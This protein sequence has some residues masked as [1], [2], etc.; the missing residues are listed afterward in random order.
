MQSRD[1]ADIMRE[2][3]TLDINAVVETRNGL[4]SSVCAGA[5]RNL[6]HLS[7]MNASTHEAIEQL[8]GL[9]DICREAN[10]LVVEIRGRLAEGDAEQDELMQAM[11]GLSRIADEVR[12]ASHEADTTVHGAHGDNVIVLANHRG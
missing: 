9:L 12:V 3:L 2:D 4:T 5:L 6:Q 1:G 8:Q 11:A 7:R 10:D